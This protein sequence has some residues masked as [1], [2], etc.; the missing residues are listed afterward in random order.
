M[1]ENCNLG[2]HGGPDA[3]IKQMT[4]P[5]SLWR[6]ILLNFVFDYVF[7]IE[8][9]IQIFPLGPLVNLYAPRPPPRG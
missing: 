3:P 2:P 8:E 9:E 4:S 7:S 6:I 5:F 1:F